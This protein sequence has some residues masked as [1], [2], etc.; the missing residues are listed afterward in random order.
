MSDRR[1]VWATLASLLA[2]LEKGVE[3]HLPSDGPEELAKEVRKLGK[4]QFKSNLLVEEQAARLEE[5]LAELKAQRDQQAAG[6]EQR[7]S[8]EVDTA[9]QKWLGS[10]LPALDGLDQAIASGKRYLVKRDLAAQLPNLTPVQ[11]EL[12]SPAD[13]AILASWL[14]GLRLVRERLL[15]ILEEGGVTPISTVGQP[16]DPYKHI[17][18]ATTTQGAAEPGT[19]IAEERRGYCT[20]AGVLRYAE[21]VVYRPDRHS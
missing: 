10:M 3:A 11:A 9:R 13:R 8:E 17:A 2:R 6:L 1:Q 4:V 16:F 19:I 21:V 7:I 5:A 18:V 14:D 20:E 15:A 12:V